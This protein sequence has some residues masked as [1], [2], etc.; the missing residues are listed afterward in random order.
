MI[1]YIVKTVTPAIIKLGR[2]QNTKQRYASYS[3][4]NTIEKVILEIEGDCEDILKKSFM[5]SSKFIQRRSWG[6]EWFA[7]DGDDLGIDICG[8]LANMFSVLFGDP[9]DL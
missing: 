9:M 3:G 5:N 4:A 8:V 6:C 7:H 2:T 1:T